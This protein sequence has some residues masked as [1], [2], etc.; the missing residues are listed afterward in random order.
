MALIR[1]NTSGGGG[2]DTPTLEYD[3]YSSYITSATTSKTISG[4]HDF[5]QVVIYNVNSTTLPPTYNGV[6]YSWKIDR[7]SGNGA[8]SVLVP[9]VKDNTAIRFSG[10]VN[11]VG[12]HG[13][14]YT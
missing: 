6:S 4:D 1:A 8:G 12:F 14:S 10:N 13:L 9:N 11:F 2:G 5:V 3:G 7:S